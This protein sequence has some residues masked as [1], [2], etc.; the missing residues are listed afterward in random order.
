MLVGGRLSLA[1]QKC[2]R[3]G[4]VGWW[5]DT[6]GTKEERNV[7]Y[8]DLAVKKVAASAHSSFVTAAWL[9][10]RNHGEVATRKQLATAAASAKTAAT[11]PCVLTLTSATT[12]A[13]LQRSNR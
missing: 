4:G 13:S 3:I 5:P 6:A 9:T 11:S 12:T 7:S 2:C 8:K 1:A 10:T